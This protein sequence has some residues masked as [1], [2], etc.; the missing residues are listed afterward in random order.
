MIPSASPF[1]ISFILRTCLLSLMLM[2]YFWVGTFF[3]RQT[4]YLAV[5]FRSVL[6][7]VVVSNPSNYVYIFPSSIFLGG[8]IFTEIS[9]LTAIIFMMRFFRHQG[10]DSLNLAIIFI[11]SIFHGW[12]HISGFMTFTI[13]L[14]ILLIGMQ[15]LAVVNNRL[16]HRWKPVS[17]LSMVA[18]SR[19][20]RPM[21]VIMLSPLMIYLTYDSI[22]LA[23]LPPGVYI[24]EKLLPIPISIQMF[25]ILMVASFIIGL[26]GLVL[27]WKL[28]SRDTGGIWP[29]SL[30]TGTKTKVL[31]VGAY[32]FSFVGMIIASTL[33]PSRYAYSISSGTTGY[34]S[35]L[36]AMNLVPVLSYIA[37]MALFFLASFGLL[38]MLKSRNQI[39]RFFAFFYLGSYYFFALLWF[40]G[41][42]SPERS[43]FFLLIVPLLIGGSLFA[44]SFSLSNIL[45]R[46]VSGT[47]RITRIANKIAV[48]IVIVFLIIAVISRANSEPIVR[49]VSQSRTILSFGSTSLPFATTELIDAVKKFQIPG[50]AILSMPE[51]QSVLYAFLSMKVFCSGYIVYTYDDA[52]NKNFY[53]MVQSLYY[54]SGGTPSDW[55]HRHNGTL[56]VIGY[57]D[58]NGGPPSIGGYVLPIDKLTND[59]SLKLVWEDSYGEKIFQLNSSAG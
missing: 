22:L 45:Q 23:H 6:F 38:T 48:L 57:M 43:M 33:D 21:Y 53:D 32:L 1:E 50:Y 27:G 55:L 40:L 3:S 14:M 46:F 28:Q 54:L 26:V 25:V 5:F 18:R 20:L 10:P 59:T 16:L 37:G 12:T 41:L 17:I 44:F 35:V 24:I 4:A 42:L 15:M 34:P 8:G 56:V 29:I 36:P 11:S 9:I 52:S 13:F 30:R 51:T 7:I 49:D 31:L 58:A 39:S 19:L 47:L 2:L